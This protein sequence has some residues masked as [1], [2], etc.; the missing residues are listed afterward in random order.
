[1]SV[2]LKDPKASFNWITGE[3]FR[4][5]KKAE[6]DISDS[7]VSATELGLLV[8]A[9]EEGSLP[10]SKGKEILNNMWETGTSAEILIEKQMSESALS[11]SDLENW[12]EEVLTENR[13]QVEEFR[14]GKEKILGFLV[15]Q[16]M[17]KS[18]GRGD[19][20]LINDELLK[21]LR[22]QN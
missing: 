8:L 9:M 17:K 16:V 21:K 13:K 1:L 12:L 6:V 14:A 18:K 4:L 10:K 20:R 2:G 5:L 3:L 19:P 7:K 22:A 11:I 15:G